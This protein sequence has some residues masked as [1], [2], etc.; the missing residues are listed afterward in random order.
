MASA[1]RILPAVDPVRVR[2][3]ELVDALCDALRADPQAPPADDGVLPLATA[4]E[5]LEWSRRRLRSYCLAHGVPVLG[6]GRVSAVDLGAVRASLASQP[7]VRHDAP[8]SELADDACVVRGR[9]GIVR[10]A[11]TSA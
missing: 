5:R 1:A 6:A 10:R 4:C 11:Y 3:H 9:R 2:L 7:R 8:S